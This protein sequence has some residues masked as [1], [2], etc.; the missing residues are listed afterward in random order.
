[1][2]FSDADFG[3]AKYHIEDDIARP[4]LTGAKCD[5]SCRGQHSRSFHQ[6][7]NEQSNR[8]T[9]FSSMCNPL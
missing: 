8:A 5:H 3:G 7:L 9:N 6:S 2:H 1:M 4:N